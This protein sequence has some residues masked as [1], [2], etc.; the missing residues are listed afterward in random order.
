MTLPR[1]LR[2]LSLALLPA[3]AAC[4]VKGPPLPPLGHR[5]VPVAGFSARQQGSTL[6]LEGKLPD[7]YTD[8]VKLEQTPELTVVRELPGGKPQTLR[9]IPADEVGALPGGTLQLSIPMEEIFGGISAERVTL[10]LILKTANGKA[11]RP[12]RSVEVVRAEAPPPPRGV[13]AG[14]EEPGVRLSWDAVSAEGSVEYHV[15][16][17]QG[18]SGPW[19]GPLGGHGLKETTYL[20]RAVQFNL[21]Y[22]YQVRSQ[23]VDS[24]PVRESDAAEPLTVRRVDQ[25]PPDPPTAV[26]AV[27]VPGGIR[28][29]WFPPESA[30]LAGFRLYRTVAGERRLLVELPADAG[31]YV[32]EEVRSGTGYRYSLS[33]VDGAVAPNESPLSGATEEARVDAEGG[34]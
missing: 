10:H 14:N 3:L 20:D 9:R 5:P 11:S 24:Q 21:S 22:Q 16:R 18:A 19:Q 33:A 8:G 6:L 31:F 2:Y 25:F 7:V 1:H 32:D 12:G 17:R 27:S 29:F 26:R 4:G 13:L 23:V 34:P 30:D 15:Y 28:I